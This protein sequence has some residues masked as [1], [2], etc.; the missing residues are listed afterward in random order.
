MSH[1]NLQDVYVGR[2]VR[3]GSA[4]FLY[5][6]MKE[7]DPEINISHRELPSFEQHIA[8][9]ERRAFRRWYLIDVKE[10]PFDRLGWA[11][12]VSATHRNE[13]G[14][15]LKRSHRGMGYG[16]EALREF[17]ARNE[18][19]PADPGAR[20]GRWLANIAP[21]NTHSRHVF[22]KLGFLKIQETYALGGG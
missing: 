8:F 16:P 22:E 12:Y 15:V 17:I 20:N 3:P 14:I 18:P 10:G 11:G 7:R 1:L 21:T 6:L 4:E 9:I 5:E 19:L 2:L 13:I